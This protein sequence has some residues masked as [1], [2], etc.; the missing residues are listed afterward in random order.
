LVVVPDGT[1][2]IWLH[3]PQRDAVDRA[4]REEGQLLRK[5]LPFSPLPEPVKC[6][7]MARNSGTF[8]NIGEKRRGRLIG[9]SAD[10]SA[11]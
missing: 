8:G 4:V 11:W 2:S 3:P 10:S 7:I 9:Y 1:L 5:A 6:E